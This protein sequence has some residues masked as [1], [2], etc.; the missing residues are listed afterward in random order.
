[1]LVTGAME[2]AGG[3]GTRI[4]YAETEEKPAPKL[5]S[6]SSPA[7]P[8]EISAFEAIQ[9]RLEEY[10]K[11]AIISPTEMNVRRYM[12]LEA[13]VV[14]QAS[15]FA[16][17][18]QRV[19]WTNPE[20]DNT[21][22]GRPVNARAL[23]VFNREEAAARIQTVSHLARTHALFF[24]FRGDCPYCHAF[25]PTLLE[26]QAKHGLMIVPIS[27]DGGALPQFPQPR[28][29]NGISRTLNI[30]QVP[31]VFLAEPF[32]GKITP[33]GF[34]VLSESQLLERIH[35]V[36]NAGKDEPASSASKRLSLR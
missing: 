21:V 3:S 8:P 9:K 20:L 27:I 2:N 4:R 10:R 36:A 18:A 35:I 14:R 34:G 15:H 1:M 32:S 24:F 23:E 22:G 31:A 30:T 6:T 25:A 33:L 13:Q 5:D 28:L 17:V 29:D 11:V 16:D 7:V 12:E 26:L 19:G